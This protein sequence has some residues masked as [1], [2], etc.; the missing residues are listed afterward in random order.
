M[1]MRNLLKPV[2]A[3]I[4]DYPVAL[5]VPRRGKFQPLQNGA[6][7]GKEI[8]P[9]RRRGLLQE[10]VK[11]DVGALGGDQNMLRGLRAN[12]LHDQGEIR[13]HDGVAG[14]FALENTRKP[15]KSNRSGQIC[16]SF[17]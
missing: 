15:T 9:F 10:M 17:I 7:R 12:I 1:Q 6:D 4:G 3:G 13:L 8:V 11:G 14:Q 2:L 16:F 5:A